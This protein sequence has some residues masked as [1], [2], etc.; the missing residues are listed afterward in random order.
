MK[1]QFF[2]IDFDSTFISVESLDELASIALRKHP[3]KAVIIEKIQEIT[4]LG[5]EGKIPFSES[6]KCR[7]G[8]FSAHKKHIAL[9]L[10]FLKRHITPSISRNNPFF[11]KHKEE[12]YII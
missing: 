1:K 7:M 5:M 12:I 2:I 3:Q 11:Q 6:L 4:R 9:L 10:L 8:L